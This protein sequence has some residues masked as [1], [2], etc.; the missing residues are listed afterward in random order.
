MIKSNSV[1]IG[2]SLLLASV[3][4]T[5]ALADNF[6]PERG[7]RCDES[8]RVCYERGIPSVETT[9][10][11]FGHRAAKRL[12]RDLRWE[13]RG[14]GARTFYPE[15]GVRCD[16]SEQVC[17]NRHGEPSFHLTRR[18]LGS[19]AARPLAWRGPGRDYWDYRAN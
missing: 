19:D 11:Y 7:V 14:Y 8:A 17:Y 5:P 13:E 18:Y 9:G 3:G 4:A 10:R 12:A 2:A 1:F 16:R 15:R 6:R